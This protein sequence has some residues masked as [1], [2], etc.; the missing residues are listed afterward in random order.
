MYTINNEVTK[1]SSNNTDNST[2]NSKLVSPSFM[3]ASQL[4]AVY[5]S[6]GDTESNRKRA[7]THCK[8]YAETYVNENGEVVHLTDWRLP[9]A[10]EIGIIVKF[11]TKSEV[12]NVVLGGRYYFCASGTVGTGITGNND[13]Y[14][15]RCIRDV[16]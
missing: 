4:G 5:S 15:L 8:E 12:M 3:I 16:Y 2:E 1:N 14:F 9:T 11:Q 10:A 7:R 13:G 6:G